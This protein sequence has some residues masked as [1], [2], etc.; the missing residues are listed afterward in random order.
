MW[1]NVLRQAKEWRT[2]Q[3]KR[4]TSPFFL[5]FLY[6]MRWFW[7]AGSNMGSSISIPSRH[8]QRSSSRISSMSQA[9]SRTS[10]PRIN[11]FQ[12]CWTDSFIDTYTPFYMIIQQ[13]DKYEHGMCVINIFIVVLYL[14]LGQTGNQFWCCNFMPFIKTSFSICLVEIRYILLILVSRMGNKSRY[15]TSHS[16]CRCIPRKKYTT[17]DIITQF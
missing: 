15:N 8:G 6:V 2:F 11:T 4:R 5:I 1:S 3:L 7:L 16:E 17:A 14:V 10:I 9:Q 13:K 12:V